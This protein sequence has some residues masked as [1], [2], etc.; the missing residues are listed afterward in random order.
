MNRTETND[1][2]SSKNMRESCPSELYAKPK[3]TISNSFYKPLMNNKK[4]SIN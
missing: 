3:T 2:F 4:P 1:R